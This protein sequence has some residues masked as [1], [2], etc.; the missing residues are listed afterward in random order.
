MNYAITGMFW[1]NQEGI[2]RQ[3]C[4]AP[5]DYAITRMF[6]RNQEGIARQGCRA[7]TDYAI[8][9]CIVFKKEIQ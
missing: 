5:T 2:A 1:R 9:E 6:W 3:G 4:R 7:P 8:I